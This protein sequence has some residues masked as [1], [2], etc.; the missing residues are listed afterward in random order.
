MA[1]K[2]PAKIALLEVD[3]FLPMVWGNQGREHDDLRFNDFLGDG[4]VWVYDG[5]A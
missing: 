4:V 3:S 1:S 5:E 2:L